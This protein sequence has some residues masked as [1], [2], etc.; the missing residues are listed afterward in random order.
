MAW[1]D[2]LLAFTTVIFAGALVP[3]ILHRGTQIS[4]KTSVPT[5]CAVWVQSAVFFS[6]QLWWTTAGTIL[7]AIL[8][9]YLALERPL[10]RAALP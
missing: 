10:R 4:R 5:A 3:S 7:I 9:T 8:W 2:L 1:Q 6:L